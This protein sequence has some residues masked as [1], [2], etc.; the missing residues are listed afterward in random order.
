MATPGQVLEH[1]FRAAE[2]P[3]GVDH[4]L[5]PRDAGEPA[6]PARRLGQ[7]TQSSVKLHVASLVRLLKQPSIAVAKHAA[8][9]A[10]RQEV[11]RL[12]RN[13]P[14]AVGR[15][16]AAAGDAVEMRV[17]HQ[18]LA[19]GVQHRQHADFVRA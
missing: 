6:A 18:V 5:A 14:P 8:Q 9:H 10:H 16:A 12:R 2:R 4:P 15:Q 13:P 7:R 19:P 3:L 1:Q 17:M 11:V